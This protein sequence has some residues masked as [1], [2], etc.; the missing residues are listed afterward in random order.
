MGL[1]CAVGDVPRTGLA[2]GAVRPLS[3]SRWRCARGACPRGA[4]V[5]ARGRGRS[6]RSWYP[7]THV[8]ASREVDRDA[9]S[10]SSTAWPLRP[11]RRRRHGPRDQAM[12]RRRPPCRQGERPHRRPRR[13][14]RALRFA[15]RHGIRARVAARVAAVRH[16]QDKMQA[17]RASR[18]SPWASPGRWCGRGNRGLFAASCPSS[19]APGVQKS[20]LFSANAGARDERHRGAHGADTVHEPAALG[21]RR[22]RGGRHRA[23][24]SRRRLSSPRCAS[25]RAAACA[26]RG[27]LSLGQL[28]EL[29]TGAAATWARGTVM[30]TSFSYFA[31]TASARRRG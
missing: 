29:Y 18:R 9:T 14:C 21:D 24:S 8:A 5:V 20:A 12:A 10:S 13:R 3:A 23:R 19:R 31:T 30:L 17:S 15:Q 1:R 6:R 25:R 7:E 4:N 22:R 26:P 16:A 2:S 11:S 28:A 27:L